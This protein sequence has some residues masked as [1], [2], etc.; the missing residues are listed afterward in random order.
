MSRRLLSITGLEKPVERPRAPL[1]ASLGPSQP[2]FSMP[3]EHRMWNRRVLELSTG[4][5]SEKTADWMNRKALEIA[6]SAMMSTG[7]ILAR[8]QHFADWHI[9]ATRYGWLVAVYSDQ[10]QEGERLDENKCP[11]DLWECMVYATERHRADFIMF[12][13]DIDLI[14]ELPEYNW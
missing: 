13:N 4:H 7:E 3:N 6:E 1:R 9:A 5:V 12:D 8:G 11:N 2:A 10:W 14:T